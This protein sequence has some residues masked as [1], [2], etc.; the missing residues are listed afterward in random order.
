MDFFSSSCIPPQNRVHTPAIALAE[1]V[2]MVEEM[3]EIVEVFTF[4]IARIQ[5]P[6]S[7]IGGVKSRREAAEQFGKGQVGL[8]MAVVNGR[9]NQDRFAGGGDQ[10]IATPQIAV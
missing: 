5:R 7:L 4:L 9:V 2:E 8:A 10:P 1:E 3:V 6:G